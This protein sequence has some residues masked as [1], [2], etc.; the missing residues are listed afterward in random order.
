MTCSAHA[1]P[2]AMGGIQIQPLLI[3]MYE[4]GAHLREG[5]LV[6]RTPRIELER[7]NLLA[8]LRR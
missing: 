2:F 5:E 6:L 1:K 7:I 4:R 3:S 8:S